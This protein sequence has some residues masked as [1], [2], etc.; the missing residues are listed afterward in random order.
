MKGSAR[1]LKFLLSVDAGSALV[2]NSV[3]QTPLHLSVE[4]GHL[5]TVVLL[6]ETVSQCAKIKNDNGNLPL[7]NALELGNSL[8]DMAQIVVCLMT[9][10]KA[11]LYVTNNEGQYP[12]HI[13][14]SSG[15][16]AGIRTILALDY[17]LIHIRDEAEKLSAL[18]IAIDSLN[19]EVDEENFLSSSTRREAMFSQKPYIQCIEILL[20]STLYK[21]FV[22]CP[23]L[24]EEVTPFLPLHGAIASHPK[25]FTWKTIRFL[26]GCDSKNQLNGL[27]RNAAHILCS[28]ATL[29]DG[30]GSIILDDLDSGLFQQADS[31]G[32]LPIHLCSMNPEVPYNFFRKVGSKNEDGLNTPVPYR[33]ENKYSMLTALQIAAT[34]NCCLDVMSYLV[35]RST[36]NK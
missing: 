34:S 25:E 31:F 35:R 23:H 22:P 27:G 21:R 15:F 26:Y 4:N 19:L 11:A 9:A 32:F 14:A 6:T 17:N 16:Q 33:M 13:A 30:I 5:P 10:F 12:I 28:I 29:G 20:S 18:D 8:D 24:S 36:N 7:H 2:R 3:G 1:V